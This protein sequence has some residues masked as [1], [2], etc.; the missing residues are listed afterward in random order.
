MRASLR[1]V[2]GQVNSLSS[3][4]ASDNLRAMVIKVH[5]LAARLG[6]QVEG[7]DHLEVTGLAPIARAQASDVTFAE[8]PKHCAA[9]E[10]CAATVVIVPLNAP[11]SRKTLIRVKNPRAAF[12]LALGIFH[13]PRPYPAQIHPTAQ[14]G[15]NV[16]LGEG[17]FVGEYAVLRDSVAIGRR[18]V[19]E[20]HCVIGEGSRLGDNC[21][22]YPNVTIY[23]DIRIADRVV[24]HAGS[25]I[26]SDGFG[27]VQDGAER[28]KI[29]QVG[30]VVIEDD[31]EIG[32][33]VTIDRATMDSTIIR[34]G[35]KI[36]NLVQIAHNVTLGQN[37]TIISQ[38]GIA[39][40]VQIGDNVTL[41]GQV[42]IADHL[43][44]GSNSVVG[45]QSGVAEDVP[46]NSIMF[47]TPA[48][49]MMQTK[50]QIIA[51][52]KLPELLRKFGKTT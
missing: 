39:G 51:L 37:C 14:L 47:G 10:G 42:G 4:W 38:V 6:G 29:P 52:R 9:A 25:V 16:L 36:D 35:T 41:A 20:A 17:V 26:G 44:V 27:Y 3:R 43:K 11:A 15:R 21:R 8:N 40:S 32:A 1:P 48:Q 33:N 19:I 22:L 31:V 45:A 28:L 2:P 46:P 5:D 13:P 24:V 12:A 7:D 34:R 23:H 50:R 18:T 49:P 30:D